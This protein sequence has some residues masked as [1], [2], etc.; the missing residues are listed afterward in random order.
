[1]YRNQD[2]SLPD[3]L[4]PGV[5]ELLRLKDKFRLGILAG[6]PTYLLTHFLRQ[7]QYAAFMAGVP[8]VPFTDQTILFSWGTSNRVLLVDYQLLTAAPGELQNV[9]TLHPWDQKQEYDNSLAK[10]S[11]VILELLGNLDASTDLRM[12]SAMISDEV[13][14][15]LRNA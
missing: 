8:D 4:R 7:V 11:D 10:L 9:I 14:R 15:R 6:E 5:L 12:Y 1:M 3:V 13:A 2:A